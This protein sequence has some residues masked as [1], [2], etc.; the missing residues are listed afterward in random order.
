M[1]SSITVRHN[2]ECGHRLPHIGGKCT[3]LHGH[4]WWATVTV[5]SAEPLHGMVVE[6][7]GFKK[8]L[9][10]WV[11]EHLDHGVM[12]GD[13]DPLATILPAFG[14]VLVFQPDQPG[15]TQGLA[16]PTVENV[17]TLLSRVGQQVLGTVTRAPGAA[18]TQVDV[19]ETHVNTATWSTSEDQ[20]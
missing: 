18:V 1:G 20:S 10:Q 13:Q 15:L 8:G 6:F 7:G 4:S 14:K 2:F 16:Y 5:S 12:L 9:R 17:A 19:Q 3:N 11:D